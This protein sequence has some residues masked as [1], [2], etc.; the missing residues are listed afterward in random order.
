[1][2][3]DEDELTDSSHSNEVFMTEVSP[4]PISTNFNE[5][6]PSTSFSVPDSSSMRSQFSVGEP[7]YATNEVQQLD[8]TALSYPQPFFNPQPL[9]MNPQLNLL[10]NMAA[11]NT[12]DSPLWDQWMCLLA[13]NLTHSQWHAY[14]HAYAALFG[15]NAL[16]TRLS[17]FN[18]FF[19]LGRDSMEG[20]GQSAHG[21]LLAVHRFFQHSA[22]PSIGSVRND[23]KRPS[24]P[25]QSDD[26]GAAATQP[27][28]L[29]LPDHVRRPEPSRHPQRDVSVPVVS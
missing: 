20:M 23:G 26:C 22:I 19:W 12:A 10:S 16:P 9:Q 7:R 27:P 24:Q 13:K 6:Q 5:N 18:D 14:W 3:S 11:P 29:G 1:M 4:L 8:T 28:L 15:V 17:F 21:D 25:R 2:H